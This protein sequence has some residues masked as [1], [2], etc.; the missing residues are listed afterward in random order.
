MLLGLG[1]AVRSLLVTNLS[2]PNPQ[3]KPECSPS[4][5][6]NGSKLAFEVERPGTSFTDLCVYD[7]TT[8]ERKLLGRDRNESSQQPRLDEA[9][10]RLVFASFASDWTS[11]DDNSVSDVFL[12]DLQSDRVRRLLQPNPLPGVSASY[13]PTIARDGRQAAF[14]SYGVP[15]PGTTRGRNVCLWREGAE[16]AFSVVDHYRGRGPVLGAPSFSPD[17]DR[18]AFSCFA[19]DMLPEI[20]KDIHYNVY[21]MPLTAAAPWPPAE[22]TPWRY[23][24]LRSM[25]PISLLSHRPDGDSCDANSLEPV[26]LEKEC[27]FSSLADDLVE[28]DINDCHDLFVRELTGRARTI[29]LTPGAN[30]SSFEP[31]ASRD[32]RFVAFTSY[33]TN[34][35]PGAR[36]G[37]SYVYLLDRASHKLQRLGPGHNPTICSDA[38]KVALVEGGQVYLW[39]ATE[40]LRRLP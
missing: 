20:P 13:R 7:L 11:G 29:C 14:L 22:P 12:Y 31:C 17:G 27:I 39:T 1:F 16:H 24:G 10:Q 9:G 23:P 32:G 2:P 15:D 4:L 34:L 36:A 30:D 40:G 38:S 26:L 33:A 5:A 19:Y 21:L 37:Q 3:P 35:L 6:G 8:H 28:N 18:I 25:W